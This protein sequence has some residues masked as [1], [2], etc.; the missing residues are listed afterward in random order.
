MSNA[1]SDFLAGLQTTALGSVVSYANEQFST[2]LN[3]KTCVQHAQGG[4]NRS[5]WVR[6]CTTSSLQDFIKYMQAEDLNLWPLPTDPYHMVPTIVLS[7][8]EL[9]LKLS[10][11]CGSIKTPYHRHTMCNQAML[12]TWSTDLRKSIKVAL[13]NHATPQLM[14][15]H[16]AEQAK[17]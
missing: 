14:H 9:M 11:S 17:K 16:I 13:L 1:P 12:N 5:D 3:G 6:L 8:N 2:M 10:V 15:D 4:D 7:P